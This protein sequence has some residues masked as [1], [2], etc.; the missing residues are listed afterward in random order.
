MG[1]SNL[2][3]YTNKGKDKMEKYGGLWEKIKG[4]I[5]SASSIRLNS[6]DLLLIKLVFYNHKNTF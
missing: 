1:I 5:I 2:L 3:V 6:H 4:L